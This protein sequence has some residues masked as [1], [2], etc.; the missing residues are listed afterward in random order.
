MVFLL[1]LT[2]CNDQDDFS[3][4][5]LQGLSLYWDHEVFGDEGRRFRFSFMAQNQFDEQ[6]TLI[7]EPSVKDRVITFKMVRSINQGECPKFPMPTL[8]PND[9]SRCDAEGRAFIAEN[10]LPPGSYSL[11]V[12]TPFFRETAELTV[13]REVVELN[14]PPNPHFYTSIPKVYPLP[15]DLLFGS[16]VDSGDE[17]LETG[18]S[19]IKELENLGL[20]PDRQA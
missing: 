13:G 7:F 2:A 14:I 10:Q 16:V 18:R 6:H 17:K 1:F 12:V 4:P 9:P 20:V 3:I 11:H 8:P 19:F 5:E 15:K